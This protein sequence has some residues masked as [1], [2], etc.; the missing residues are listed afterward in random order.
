MEQTKHIVV[1]VAGHVDHG[2]TLL[3][4]ALTGVDTDRL[5]DEKRRGMT[6]VPGFAPLPVSD[7][8]HLALIDVPG[9]ERFVKN[10]LSGVGGIDMALLVVAADE[11]V[12]PQTL[13]HLHILEL[14]GIDKGVAVISKIDGVDGE[15]RAA[16]RR[17]LEQTLAGTL[18]QNAPVIEASAYTGENILLVKEALAAVAMQTA[19]KSAAGFCRL[20][21]DRVFSK[22]GFG[23]VV[24]GTLWMGRIREGQILQLTPGETLARVRGLQAYGK[25]VAEAAAGSRVAVNLAGV[26]VQDIPVGSWLAEPRTLRAASRLDAA[27]SLLSDAAPLKDQ[28]RLW[29]HHGAGRVMGRIRLLD[30]AELQPGQ[31]RFAQ[32]QLAA[33]L[34][35]VVGDRLILRRHSPAATVGGGAVLAV[36]PPRHKRFDGAVLRELTVKQKGDGPAMTGDLLRRQAQPLPAAAV[37]RLCGMP[38]EEADAALAL[39]T[40]RGKAL[41]LPAGKETYYLDAQIAEEQKLHIL[42]A[43]DAYHRRYPLRAGMPAAE[44][45]Q[46]FLAAYPPKAVGVLLQKWQDGAFLQVKGSLV[47]VFGFHSRPSRQQREILKRLTAIYERAGLSPEPWEQVIKKIPLSPAEAGDYL[48]WLAEQG[49]LCRC[50][51][52]W[53][54]VAALERGEALLRRRFAEEPFTLAQARDVLGVSRKYALLLLEYLDQRKIT[55]RQQDSRSFRVQ[56]KSRQA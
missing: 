33:P 32:I 4:A 45:R 1:G 36:D 35:P 44:L 28:D 40:D 24:T 18:L 11:G 8:L 12:M 50:G 55:L 20:P 10:M 21:I 42:Q 17:Q 48:Q 49:R 54:S 53:F 29:V 23:T 7:R 5:P 19:A 46:R 14:L 34:C 56:G 38:P 47:S 15:R 16:A 25:T 26:E 39:L 30:A 2:K 43:L 13:E 41:R 31:S 6:I 3:T 51:D 37:S 52:C 27:L 9:H 22:T